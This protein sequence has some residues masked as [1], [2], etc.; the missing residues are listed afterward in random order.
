MTIMAMKNKVLVK[1]RTKQK[2]DLFVRPTP[3]EVI[4]NALKIQKRACSLNV[5]DFTHAFTV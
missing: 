2:S 3:P 5:H 1:Q 4:Q